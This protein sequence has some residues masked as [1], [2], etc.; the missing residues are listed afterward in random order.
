MFSE[1]VRARLLA[2]ARSFG[3]LPG[4][5]AEDVV[6]ETLAALWGLSESGYPVRDA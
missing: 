5:E 6:Q 4:A 1:G 3:R 2:V